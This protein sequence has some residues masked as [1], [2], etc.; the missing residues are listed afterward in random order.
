MYPVDIQALDD[1]LGDGGFATGASATNA[2]HKCCHV[3]PLFVIPWR[4][5]R[6]VNC[7]TARSND[8]LPF[9]VDRGRC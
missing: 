7:P 4:S 2:D 8:G 6:G 9:R 1:L 3:L 5:T